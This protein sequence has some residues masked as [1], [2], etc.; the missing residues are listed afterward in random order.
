MVT[1]KG[2]LCEAG[3]FLHTNLINA[4]DFTT[5][6]TWV[7]RSN[8][9]PDF[10]LR[11]HHE[12]NRTCKYL[13]WRAFFEDARCLVLNI[14]MNAKISS[15]VFTLSCLDYSAIIM[16]FCICR[17]HVSSF[18]L[19]L[20]LDRSGEG[21]HSQKCW[22]LFQSRQYSQIFPCNILNISGNFE[23]VPGTSHLWA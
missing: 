7:R 23:H 22:V 8:R 12:T 4:V 18:S 16:K 2:F 20:K 1:Q 17:V 6:P 14:I 15:F 21:E 13:S 19:D 3:F 11:A 9:A 5:S 10:C